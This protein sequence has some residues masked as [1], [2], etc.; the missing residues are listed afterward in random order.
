MPVISALLKYRDEQEA[1][2][3]TGTKHGRPLRLGDVT[4]VNLTMIEGGVQHNVIPES[5]SAVF[6][7]RITPD[8]DVAGFIRWVEDLCAKHE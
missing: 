1:L 8:S 4:S 5:I 2:L 3:E 7:I 6:D